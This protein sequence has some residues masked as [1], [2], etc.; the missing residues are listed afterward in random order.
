MEL[1]ILLQEDLVQMI[2]IFKTFLY[3]Q[4]MEEKLEKHLFVMKIKY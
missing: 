4:V 2:Q 1:L 3:A